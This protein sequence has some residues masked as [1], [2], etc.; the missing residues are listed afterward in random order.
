MKTYQKPFVEIE[1]LS[2][3]SMLMNNVE[4]P[5]A[6][7]QGNPSSGTNTPSGFGEAGVPGRKLF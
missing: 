5:S 1:Q 4:S 6:D 2:G 3:I 7:I